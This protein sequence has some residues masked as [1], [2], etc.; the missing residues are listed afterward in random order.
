MG[1]FHDKQRNE[2]DHFILYPKKGGFESLLQQYIM[3]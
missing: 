1:L 2:V 3:I